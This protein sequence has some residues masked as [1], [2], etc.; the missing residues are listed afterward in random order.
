MA[1]RELYERSGHLAKFA[2]DMFPP[3]AAGRPTDDAHAAAEPVPAPRDDLRRPA[4]APTA[5]CRCGSPSWARCSGPSAPVSSVDCRGCA[6][7]S[8]N[9]AHNFC[10]LDQV[11]A[12]V[13]GVL[14]LMRRAHAAL[15]L[16]PG[17][18]PAVAARRGGEYARRRGRRGTLAERLLRE[19]L[20]GAGVSFVEAPGEA[21]FYGP[22]IDVQI[23][24]PAG[25]ES[26]LATVQ[27]DFHQPEQFDLSYVDADGRRRRGR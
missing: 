13:A 16:R 25:R 23:V 19:A 14:A 22:K 24:D 2:D 8:L 27:V 10:A 21:A 1:K 12:E 3:M 26:T 5:S 20:V 15:G 11:G 18:F 4:A 9:D 17:R 6:A 7:I